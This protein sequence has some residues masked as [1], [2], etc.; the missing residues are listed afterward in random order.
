MA[1]VPS[2]QGL[3]GMKPAWIAV[4]VIFSLFFLGIS[5]FL[6]TAIW[7][8]CHEI[9]V[10]M[11]KDRPRFLNLEKL[12]REWNKAALIEQR[13]RN[14]TAHLVNELIQEKGRSDNDYYLLLE[15]VR[16]LQVRD[17]Q[18]YAHVSIQV[19][20]TY[21]PARSHIPHVMLLSLYRLRNKVQYKLQAIPP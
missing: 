8:Y 7:I 12:R 9:W 6:A 21:F 1:P 10:V 16:R 15:L 3:S 13:R 18:I 11:I 4:S 2:E 5:P 20:K 14:V 19:H 17:I